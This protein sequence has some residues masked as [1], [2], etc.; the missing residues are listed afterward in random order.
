MVVFRTLS[1]MDKDYIDPWMD[2]MVRLDTE[3]QG[4][5]VNGVRSSKYN[6]QP[7]VMTNKKFTQW[8]M[9]NGHLYSADKV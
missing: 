4:M 5:F 7:I 1:S 8:A 3:A 6:K 2:Y 9:K